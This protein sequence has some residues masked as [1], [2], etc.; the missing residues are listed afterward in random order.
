MLKSVV[1]P[2]KSVVVP[3]TMPLSNVERYII[4]LLKDDLFL[5][6]QSKNESKIREVYDNSKIVDGSDWKIS[7]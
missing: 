7:Q 4:S 2:F 5:M 3:P 6:M 1:P